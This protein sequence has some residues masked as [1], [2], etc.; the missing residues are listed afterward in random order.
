VTSARDTPPD[1]SAVEFFEKRIRPLLSENCFGCH[2]GSS[3]P[4]QAGLRL[5]SRAA[6]LRGG[7]RGTA[8][9]PGAPE[10]SLLIKALRASGAPQMPPKGRM[11]E[12][13]IA[14]LER[15]VRQGA[16][17][18]GSAAAPAN[19]T[20][21][22][23]F[24]LKQRAAAHWSWKPVRMPSVPSPR[25]PK[26][27]RNPIDAFILSKLESRGLRPAPPADKRALIRRVT[28][29]L[30]GLPP[31]PA[32]VE[33]FLADK[34]PDAYERVVDRLLAS[35]HYGE[36]W[37]RH[38]LDL[39]RYAETYGHEGDYEKPNAYQYRDYVIRALNADVPYNQFVKE[40]IAGD[41]IAKPRR[42]SRLGFNES[43]LGTGFWWLGEGTHSPVDL[44]QDEADRIDNQ[45]DVFGKAFLGL[46]L[47]CAR[48]HDHKF[49]AISTKDYYALAGFLRSS[50][51]QQTALANPDAMKPAVDALESIAARRDDLLKRA[52]SAGRSNP[53]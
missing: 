4:I 36:R 7:G 32:E 31:T 44:L 52:V 33:A 10:T 8:L 39:V 5:D 46:G 11:P 3:K 6:M 49:D 37:A 21:K 51:Y 16:I 42:D 35:P 12:E 19:P 29:D 18:P 23:A 38:W 30:I 34:S 27:V 13:S 17:W 43:I 53:I 47:G 40:H 50:R 41:L 24:N 45:I 9:T 28:F 20:K 1:P 2:S 22:P 25:D 26:W 15:W 48:C 14:L